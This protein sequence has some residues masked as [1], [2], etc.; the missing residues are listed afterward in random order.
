MSES[1]QDEMIRHL[2]IARHALL[3]RVETVSKLVGA[4]KLA[5]ECQDAADYINDFMT[6]VL[7]TRDL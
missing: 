7:A 2:T 6:A 4:E 3:L 5:K 1:Q